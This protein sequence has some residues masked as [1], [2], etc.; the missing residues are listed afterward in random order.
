ME[1]RTRGVEQHA[2][3]GGE[4]SV[5]SVVIAAYR[6][7]ATLPQ[8]LHALEAQVGFG[9][10]EVV[11]VDSS[12]EL[13]EG[14]V[15]RRWPW[16]R[17][18]VL[19]ERAY[20]GRARNVGVAAAR[21]DIIAFLD[22]DAVPLPGWLDAL[23]SEL[24]P[25]VDAVA[26]AILNGTPRSFIGTA[27]Y[28]LEFADWL[29]DR[30]GRVEHAATCNLLVRREALVQSGGFREDL[31]GGE[32]TIFT[33]P[34]GRAGRLAFAPRARVQHLNRTRWRAYF[35]NQRRLGGSFGAVCHSVDF[36]HGWLARPL[37]APAAFA[38]RLVALGRRLLPHPGPLAR[39]VVLLPILVAG[40]FAWVAG[41]A[42]SGARRRSGGG[43]GAQA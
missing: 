21:G 30:R 20:P 43:G 17:Y 9:N 11:L 15:A 4:R 38:F 31:E 25:G 2:S 32:D 14:E 27:G 34:L 12:A 40:T 5:V 7:W 35:R 10:R 22:A 1:A 19:P 39:A 23:E 6:S 16:L 41:L 24:E 26:G 28:L 13:P 18:L 42:E 29:P 37:L 33:F 36:P 8:V 3:A